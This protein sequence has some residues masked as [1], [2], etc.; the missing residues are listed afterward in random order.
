MEIIPVSSVPALEHKL[1]WQ[2]YDGFAL[3]TGK[4]YIEV[5]HCGH[6]NIHMRG[7]C[8]CSNMVICP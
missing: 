7:R 2:E 4:H 6:I 5:W 3:W 1:F 8:N